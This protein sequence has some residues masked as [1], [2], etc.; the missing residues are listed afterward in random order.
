MSSTRLAARGWA[1]L[2]GMSSGNSRAPF[3]F[4]GESRRVAEDAALG[5]NTAARAAGF[6]ALR[7][8]ARVAAASWPAAAA[9]WIASGPT[10]AVGSGVALLQPLGAVAGGLRR[11]S[12]AAP[13]TVDAE[14]AP[15]KAIYQKPKKVRKKMVTWY[16]ARIST[17]PTAPIV[18]RRRPTTPSQRHTAIIDKSWLWRGGPLKGLTEGLRKTGGRNNTGRTTV[19]WR[20]G[21]NKHR[22]RIVDF[23]RTLRTYQGVRTGVIERIEY[24]PNRT[25]FIALLRH[26][27]DESKR[28]EG[29]KKQLSDYL[30]YI[31]CP[32]G[33]KVG[34]ELEASRTQQVD[35]KPGNAMP[36][37]F[38]PVGTAVHNIEMT[39]GK[40]GQLCRSAGTS[41]QLLERDETKGLAL[42]RM[43]SKEQRYVPL[44]AMATVG[45]VSNPNKKNEV[46]GKAGRNRW[47]GKRPRVRGV[48]M[49]PVD[50]PHGG[51]EGKKGTGGPPL[52][53]WGKKT[54]GMKTVRKLS[55]LIALPRWK[56]KR[57]SR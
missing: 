14:A 46:M 7:P 30:S 29:E 48:A 25:A 1:L 50:H 37:K 22:Y 55:P 39:I 38:M 43:S 23:K 8:G 3:R 41:A 5:A 54:K 24:D 45:A 42:L 9:R 49:N 21:G 56:A 44:L 20:G 19:F 31:I 17:D 52:S 33:V 47:K 51:G 40:G 27:V 18:L 28:A 57:M 2:R 26:P 15:A 11:M 10:L 16:G 35:I 34:Q 53:P 6:G 4:Q 32:Q 36:L 12:E 13:A